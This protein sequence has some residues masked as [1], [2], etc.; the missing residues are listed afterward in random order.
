MEHCISGFVQLACDQDLECNDG[1][2][3]V[4]AYIHGEAT[5]AAGGEEEIET[6]EEEE[7]ENDRNEYSGEEEMYIEWTR[8]LRENDRLIKTNQKVV[9]T[10]DRFNILFCA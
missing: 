2:E 1:S 7:V 5:E 9:D 4:E 8:R 3:L 10:E 6:E